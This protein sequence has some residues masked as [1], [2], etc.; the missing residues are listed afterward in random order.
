RP[1]STCSHSTERV[2]PTL[3]CTR[4]RGASGRAEACLWS[5]CCTF[6]TSQC[7]AL[8]CHKSVTV[9]PRRARRTG[10]AVA[11]GQAEP[12]NVGVERLGLLHV[13]HVPSTRD[14]GQLGARDGVSKLRRNAQGAAPIAVSP[15]E[16]GRDIDVPKQGGRVG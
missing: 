8:R 4:A 11:G 9:C 7:Q 16:Q 15:D 3:V 5:S 2:A 12:T 6:V 1:A 13:A 10:S 14:D